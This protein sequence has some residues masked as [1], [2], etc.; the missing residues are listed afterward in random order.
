MSRAAKNSNAN[1]TS[2]DDE[3]PILPVN[4]VPG[5]NSG[6]SVFNL[7]EDQIAQRARLEAEFFKEDMAQRAAAI[8]ILR[9]RN[10]RSA[11]ELSL[12]HI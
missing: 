6:T 3:S 9:L 10:Q 4:L 5:L 12:I 7:T 1:S 8:E 2:K 11:E